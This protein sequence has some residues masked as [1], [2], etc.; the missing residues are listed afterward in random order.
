MFWVVKNTLWIQPLKPLQPRKN[1]NDGF[2]KTL[3]IKKLPI[4]TFP[5]GNCKSVWAAL[6]GH[7]QLEFYTTI[8]TATVIFWKVHF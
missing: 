1:M 7:K 6:Q 8:L 2:E 4:W 5:N 3:W